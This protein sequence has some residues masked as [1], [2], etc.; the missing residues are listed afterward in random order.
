MD[1]IRIIKRAF[2]IT[3][4]YRALWVFGIILALTTGGSR[5]LG[6]SNGGGG[7]GGT[8]PGQ[9]HWP[10]IAP[11]VLH[12][13]IVAGITLLCVFLIVGVIATIARYVSATALI[14]MV[15]QY[16]TT[17]QKVGFRQGF[18]LGWSR[19]AL[20][21]FLLDL[22]LGLITVIAFLLL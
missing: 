9:F 21:L 6:G 4:S 14:R 3:T 20:R 16:E 1:H 12:A 11:A 5:R 22:A 10:V 13:I 18:R 17:G 7:R 15:D 2:S 19:R 8:G